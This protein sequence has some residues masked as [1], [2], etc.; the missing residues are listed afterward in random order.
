M[1][2]N[3]C[4]NTLK[5]AQAKIPTDR[6]SIWVEY[7]IDRGTIY[8]EMCWNSLETFPSVEETLFT[9]YSDISPVCKYKE[10]VFAYA[11][12]TEVYTLYRYAFRLYELTPNITFCS[13]NGIGVRRVNSTTRNALGPD[14]TRSMAR[15]VSFLINLKIA[16]N[17][18]KTIKDTEKRKYKTKKIQAG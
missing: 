2:V 15:P 13:P 1:C 5:L 4:V 10:I 3:N 14:I 8:I 6:L 17:Q 16:S 7:R 12:N 18:N 11:D 9:F